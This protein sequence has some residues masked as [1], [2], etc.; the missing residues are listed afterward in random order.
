MNI[1]NCPRDTN[2]DGDCGRILCPICGDKDL[3]NWSEDFKEAY[4]KDPIV[5]LGINN[6][7]DLKEIIVQMFRRNQKMI[8]DFT[9]FENKFVKDSISKNG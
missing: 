7:L 5:Q 3:L 9:D 6:D 4:R 2:G 1:K 8:K